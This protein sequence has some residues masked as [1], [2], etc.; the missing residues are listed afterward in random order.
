MSD[1]TDFHGAPFVT[2]SPTGL[3]K[4]LEPN[5]G[6]NYGPD[7]P[8]TVTNGIQEALNSIASTG[9]RVYC[10]QG[11]YSANGPLQ[12]TGSYQILEFAAGSTLTFGNHLT[13][14]IPTW[15]NN[16][17]AGIFVPSPA[18]IHMGSPLSQST[19]YSHQWFIGNGLQINWGSNTNNTGGGGTGNN[20]GINIYVPGIY[21]NPAY[22][23]PGGSD[24]RV[25]G[26]VLTGQV[27]GQVQWWMDDAAVSSST[28]LITSVQ[29]Y[30]DL[31]LRDITAT[32]SNDA[33]ANIASPIF[34]SGGFNILVERVNVDCSA[35][36]N[37]CDTDPILVRATTGECYSVHVK[38]CNFRMNGASGSVVEVQ[39]CGRTGVY[40]A[41]CHDILFEECTFDS[42]ATSGSPVGGQ[43]GA[44][45]DDTNSN[46]A[47]GFIWNLEFRKCKWVFCGMSFNPTSEAIT[48]GGSPFTY[49]NNGSFP[50][51]VAVTG[52]TVSNIQ[53][54]GINALTT[55]GS[56]LVRPGQAIKVT[57]SS[58]PVMSWVPFGY[59]RFAGDNP[60][61][62]SGGVSGL[63][64]RGPSDSGAV[65]PV[66]GNGSPVVVN[67]EGFDE[68]YIITG[69]TV[70][71][72][73]LNAISVGQTSGVFP[74]TATNKIEI[75]NTAAPTVTVQP[76]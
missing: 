63:T 1:W 23:G 45:I 32:Y 54:G 61:G 21:S 16:G 6:A 51:V 36:P 76:R 60:S 8:G 47:D 35:L 18:L 66:T 27:W 38:H 57:Y 55:A 10:L 31:V 7:T 24:Y 4:G 73:K 5:N 44:Y 59:V 17:G 2:V 9:G 25:E 26:L 14:L 72:I 29:Q 13:G 37:S 53:V 28:A 58:T 62:F 67:T 49:T 65:L 68:L 48:V 30:R 39:G 46:T 69:G 34:I 19:P 12:F 43:G 20:N 15:L 42:G 75:D 22:T 74:V 70:S 33:N 3:A 50:I 41:Y 11:S 64:G 71:A 40:H 56:F 52:G